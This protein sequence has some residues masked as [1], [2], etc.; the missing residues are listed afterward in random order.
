MRQHV[1]KS[2]TRGTRHAMVHRATAT[3]G[4]DNIRRMAHAGGNT[5]A[6][7]LTRENGHGCPGD[8]TSHHGPKHAIGQSDNGVRG[9]VHHDVCHTNTNEV[10]MS[11]TQAEFVA[12]ILADTKG[13][14]FTFNTEV[15]KSDGQTYPAEILIV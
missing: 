1:T 6:R 5:V 4:H 7:S 8:Q 15:V 3:R 9:I 12:A 13:F 11:Q 14:G 2:E 10:T